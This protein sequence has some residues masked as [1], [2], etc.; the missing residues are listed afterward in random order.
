M[1][2]INHFVVECLAVL[3]RDG[4]ERGIVG[5][6]LFSDLEFTDRVKRGMLEYILLPNKIN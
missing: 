1:L 3:L 4:Y 2:A 6:R 5:K